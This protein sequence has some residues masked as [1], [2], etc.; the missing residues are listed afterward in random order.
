MTSISHALIGAA[1]AGKISDPILACTIAIGT[2]LLC[3]MIPHWDLGTNW[4]SRQKVVTGAL[5]IAE[6]LIALIATYFIFAPLVA[7]QFLLAATIVASLIPDWIEAPYF[8]LMPHSPKFFYHMY[9]WQS[10]F[11]SRL[12]WPWGAVTQVVVVGLFLFVGFIV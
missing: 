1:I 11:H 6:T 2:H 9:K 12:V 10:Y 5:A 7:N 8:L 4:R 3:D